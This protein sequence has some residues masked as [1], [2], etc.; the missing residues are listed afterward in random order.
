MLFLSIMYILFFII[1]FPIFVI[2]KLEKN[3]LLLNIDYFIYKYNCLYY[4]YNNNNHR[5]IY[6][7][8]LKNILYSLIINIKIPI[9]QNTLLLLINI[10]YLCKII[11]CNPFSLYRYKIQSYISI[12]STIIILVLN[13]GVLFI[14]NKNIICNIIICIQCV[15]IVL[16]AFPIIILLIIN[17][18]EYINKEKI[19]SEYVKLIINYEFKNYGG[20]NTLPI[21]SSVK[22]WVENEY[23][24]KSEIVQQIHQSANISSWAIRD[25][26]ID[27]KII[28]SI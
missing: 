10:L 5:F 20:N 24:E 4:I 19:N 17:L 15:T 25:F 7:L 14:H 23:N 12:Y 16:Y 22:K 11:V 27:K 28:S 18:Y 8:F 6:Y 2:Y 13:Y 9:L 26:Y 3:N 1:G 21:K